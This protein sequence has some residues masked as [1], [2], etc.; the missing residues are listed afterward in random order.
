MSEHMQIEVSQ[1]T[2]DAWQELVDILSQMV[3]IPAALIMRVADPDI[4]VL[5]S[6]RIKDNPYNPGDS[7]KLHGSGLYCE[8]VIKTGKKLLV[9]DALADEHWKNNPDV[10]LD[11]ISYLGFPIIMPDGRPFGTLCVLDTSPNEYSETIEKLMLKFRDLMESHLELIYVNQ[12]LGDRNKRPSDYLAEIQTLRTMVPVC[13]N[14]KSIKN[15][16]G[17]WHPIEHYLSR[18]HGAGFTHSVCPGC[19]KK[20]Y[21][22]YR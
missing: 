6:S 2:L 7:E 13:A 12:A 10:K 5:V 1:G 9:P 21:P 8:T 17:Q 20:L 3:N 14:C 19:M 22:E 16:Q 11:M 18:N 15:E 4:E